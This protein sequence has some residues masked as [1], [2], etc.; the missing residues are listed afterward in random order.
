MA[1]RPPGWKVVQ[2]VNQKKFSTGGVI[3]V[4]DDDVIHFKNSSDLALSTSL[5]DLDFV[6]LNI[7]GQSMDV[8]AP[9][10]IIHVDKDDDSIDDK[11]T[12]PHDLADSDDED[13]AN[14]DDDDDMSADLVR[15]QGSD[16]GGDDR[17]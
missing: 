1:R 4:E 15:G 6:T 2:D 10:N 3:M 13:L 11:D 16:G 8:D 7:D 12:L 9:P 5:D 14:D 17:P